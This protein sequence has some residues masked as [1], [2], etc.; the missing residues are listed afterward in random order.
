MGLPATFDPVIINFESAS[1]N[2]LTFNVVVARLLNEETRQESG[3]TGTNPEIKGEREASF[4]AA[5]G[6]GSRSD[7]ICHFCDK[8]GLQIGMPRQDE[9]GRIEGEEG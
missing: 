4:T 1:P 3:I 9:V 8:K 7:V 5:A 6:R 2:T